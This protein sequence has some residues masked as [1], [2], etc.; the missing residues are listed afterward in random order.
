MNLL[1]TGAWKEAKE[2]LNQIEKMGHTVKF[3]QYEKDDL[4]CA[5]DWAEGVVCNGLFLYHPIEK[6]SRLRYVQ[7]TS[8]G[9]DR[10]PLDYI[11]GHGIKLYNA[12]GVYSIPMA[13]WAVMSVLEIYKN[14][15]NFFEKQQKRVWEKDSSLLELTDKKVCIVG[16]GNVGRE[17]AKRF[18]SFGTQIVAVNRSK[19]EDKF[20]QKWIPLD[21]IE[22]ILPEADIVILCIA[23]TEETRNFL[24]KKRFDKMKQ[25]SVLINLSRGN[26]IDEGALCQCLREGK[27]RGVAL[28]VFHQEPLPIENE[29]WNV[30]RVILSPHNS[31]VGDMVKDRIFKLIYENLI[32]CE[33]N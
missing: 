25:E 26:V 18:S 23:L 22:E 2:Y 6:F 20:I 17:T 29:L 4:P 8:A 33:N 10:I 31:F 3:L 9:Y 14:A 27:F 21:Q 24:G 28:D 7:L 13:E 32:V 11:N 15:H 12:K 16:Y 19:V 5:Y 1:I 30:P